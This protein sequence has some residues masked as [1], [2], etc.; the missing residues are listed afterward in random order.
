VD[1]RA[2]ARSMAAAILQ[3]S[4]AIGAD[5]IAE[6]VE[7]EAEATTLVDLGYTAAQGFLFAAPM[8][9][10]ELRARL[11]AESALAKSAGL[12]IA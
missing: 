12:R 11:C 1:I 8:P 9:I 4:A 10:E 3:L 5:M 6:G 2:E 7:T